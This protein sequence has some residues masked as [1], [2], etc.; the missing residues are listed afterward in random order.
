MPR[1]NDKQSQEKRFKNALFK[2][3]ERGIEDSGLSGSGQ[4]AGL[5]GKSPSCWYTRKNNPGSF[6]ID[7]LIIVAN[8]MKIS[9]SE[10]FKIC[11][12]K[13]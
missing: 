9:L 12:G 3:I 2:V 5:F 4:Q 8:K 7:E 11:E 10:L 13:I 1:L 6:T